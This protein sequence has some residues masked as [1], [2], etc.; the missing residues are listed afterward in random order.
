ML[1]SYDYDS[2]TEL[3]SCAGS[4]VVNLAGVN[5]CLLHYSELMGISPAQAAEY[6]KLFGL[7]NTPSQSEVRGERTFADVG[8]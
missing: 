6:L 4:A 3:C 8:R 7:T 1:D 2:P 5:L